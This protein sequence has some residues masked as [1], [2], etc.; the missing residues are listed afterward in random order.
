ML[1]QK[2]EKKNISWKCVD[3][4]TISSMGLTSGVR[5][6]MRISVQFIDLWTSFLASF[7]VN[8]FTF[9]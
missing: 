1:C 5:K 4:K 9:R 8:Y 2:H 6:V 3:S 7:S